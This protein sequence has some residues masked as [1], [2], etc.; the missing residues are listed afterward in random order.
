MFHNA[1]T[2]LVQTQRTNGEC[3]FNGH[4]AGS[5]LDSELLQNLEKDSIDGRSLSIAWDTSAKCSMESITDQSYRFMQESVSEADCIMSP[6]QGNEKEVMKLTKA[7][8]MTSSHEN[9]TSAQDLMTSAQN[10]LTS[11]HAEMRTSSQEKLT[12]SHDGIA[13][14]HESPLDIRKSAQN[15]LT[16]QCD[17]PLM[18]SKM[19]SSDHD[20][21]TSI[22]D[23]EVSMSSALCNQEVMT[24]SQ[25]YD[26][27]TASSHEN[28]VVMT[29][30]PKIHL[31][32]L[33][34]PE[35]VFIVGIFMFFCGNC[36][37]LALLAVRLNYLNLSKYEIVS[38]LSV[39]G[40]VGIFRI[41]PAW[42]IDK[43]GTN[44]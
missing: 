30:S 43:C 10:L 25:C 41:I 34:C 5:A 29:S 19:T 42:I 20:N 12:L 36:F 9:L 1:F 8:D 3:K 40:A 26:I 4:D 11:S 14:L 24:S 28:N 27:T 39:G 38:I 22:H 35:I 6:I 2:I 23:D 17:S 32:S 31:P 7:D 21:I 15:L 16:S 18:Q 37:F 44:R 13:S 33:S